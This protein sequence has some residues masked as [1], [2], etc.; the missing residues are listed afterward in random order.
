MD[1]RPERNPAEMLG[2]AERP[3]KICVPTRQPGKAT[4]MRIPD[5]GLQSRRSGLEPA[6][7]TSL[8]SVLEFEHAKISRPNTLSIRGVKGLARISVIMDRMKNG[9][10]EQLTSVTTRRNDF[11]PASVRTW[12]LAKVVGGLAGTGLLWPLG[13]IRLLE[14]LVAEPADRLSRGTGYIL[15]F[16]FSAPAV[17]FFIGCVELIGGKPMW[18][19]SSSWNGLTEWKQGLLS[20]LLLWLGMSLVALVLYLAVL[21][22]SP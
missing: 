4:I 12:G 21:V 17:F 1:F 15:V 8:E 9:M 14:Q 7:A 18:R 11:H 13:L 16:L 19:L 10:K 22:L 20:F 6:S 2:A 3:F 5:D